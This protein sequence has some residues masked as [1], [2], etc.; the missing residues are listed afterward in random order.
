M[1]AASCKHDYP[2]R[3]KVVAAARALADIAFVPGFAAGIEHV[4]M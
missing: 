2:T 3:Q 4:C 1:A